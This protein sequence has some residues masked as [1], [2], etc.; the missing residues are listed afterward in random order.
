MNRHIDEAGILR[1]WNIA[2]VLGMALAA[3]A[4]FAQPDP[5]RPRTAPATTIDAGTGKVLNIAIEA[6][7]AGKYDEA[8]GAIARLNLDKLSPYERSKVEQ[9]LF[10]IAYGEQNYVEAR[11]H[12]QTSVD[13]G[14]LNAQE[15]SQAHYQSAQLLMT[16]EKWNEGAAALEE[17]LATSVNPNGAAYYLLAVAY[18]QMD[19]FARALPPA[20]NAVAMMTEPQEGWIG[21]LLALHLQRKE[22]Q[23]AI[24]LLQKLVVIVPAKKTY[25]LQL[26]SVYGLV[27]DYSNALGIMQVAYNAGLLTEDSEVR[28]LADLLLFQNLP[29]RGAQV[30]EAEIDKGTVS[31]DDKVYEKLANCWI[32]AG[33]LDK[34]LAPLLRAAE[35][36]KTGNLFVRLGEL[37]VQ[38]EDWTAAQQALDRGISKGELK[39][40]ANAQMLMG[41]ALFNQQRFAEARAWFQQSLQSDQHRQMSLGYL[42]LI[43]SNLSQPELREAAPSPRTT[44]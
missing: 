42:G 7:Q 1:A 40:A 39:D 20:Q 30:L 4:T 23:D 33:E 27:E 6:L 22:Y 31:V 43:E 36:S 18:Y 8:K 10:N 34:A 15:I 21:L 12:L 24:V 16:Q 29:Y 11:Q 2:A 9:I 19:D 41:I 25:W 13:A 14:G 35:L 37:N 44:L 17:W 28:R 32:A 3:T 26:S 38:R 5:G